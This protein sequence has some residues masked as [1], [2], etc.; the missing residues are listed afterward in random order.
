VL[1]MEKS[2]HFTVCAD[3]SVTCRVLF[4]RFGRYRCRVLFV[5]LVVDRV[6]VKRVSS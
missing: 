4:V 1:V 5:L 3:E 6:P 2:L